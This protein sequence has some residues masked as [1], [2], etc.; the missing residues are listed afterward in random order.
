MLNC[1]SVKVD[2]VIIID[3]GHGVVERSGSSFL[4]VLRVVRS[5][6]LT[7][8]VYVRTDSR[9]NSRDTSVP[10]PYQ[11]YRLPLFACFALT[12]VMH[13]RVEAGHRVV[14]CRVVIGKTSWKNS[15]QQ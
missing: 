2:H 11:V 9:L 13:H 3:D 7:L 10:L 4:H 5:G 8:Y 1:E 12:L 15:K 14:D 6:L